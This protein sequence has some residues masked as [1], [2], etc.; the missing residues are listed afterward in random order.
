MKKLIIFAL[1]LIS[2]YLG[3]QELTQYNPETFS[4]IG[5]YQGEPIFVCQQNANYKLSESEKPG[6][7]YKAT[8]INGFLSFSIFKEID[9]KTFGDAL[10]VMNECIG[11][12][13]YYGGNV[14]TIYCKNEIK[15]IEFMSDVFNGSYALTDNLELVVSPSDGKNIHLEYIVIN[16]SPI[17]KVRLPLI[18]NNSICIGDYIY[19]TT[20]H[21]NPE[22]TYYPLDIYRVKI[23]D[24]NNP[25]LLL[26]EAVES[27]MPIPN[28]DII[29]TRISINGNLENVY[30]NTANKTYEI[31]NDR[32]NPQ[33]IKYKGKYMINNTCKDK[34]TGE[35]RY[36]LKELPVFNSANFMKDNRKISDNLIAINLSNSQKPFLNTFITDE[37]LYNAPESEL[38]KLDKRQLR[39]LRNAFFARQGYQF[40]N[41]DLQKFFG[42]F[43]WYNKLLKSYKVIEI[44]NEDIV[45][46]P[47]DKERV[48]LIIKIENSK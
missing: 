19:F 38:S 36:C 18:G 48:E 15:R 1:I 8:E 44:T 22:Y 4:H 43:E 6:S 3:A 45:I 32:F 46:S 7:L 28:T 30:Y 11:Y 23:G 42:Q 34:A 5:Y 40:E 35:T 12:D 2:S 13:S 25:E 29:Y 41:S 16:K 26:Q 37:L 9:R 33:L 10:F 14:L 47:K 17:E 39:L 24:W 21:I 20:Y 27:W 31:T